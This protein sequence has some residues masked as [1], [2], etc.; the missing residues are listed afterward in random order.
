MEFIAHRLFQ[1]RKLIDRDA[2]HNVDF[3][4]LIAVNV[5]GLRTDGQ[6]SDLINDGVPIV[7]IMRVT[8]GNDALIDYP[9][10]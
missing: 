4:G 3:T 2:I 5:C 6:I 10:R 1:L 8:H 7:P 9:L